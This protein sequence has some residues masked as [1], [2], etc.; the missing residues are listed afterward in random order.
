MRRFKLW[1][2]AVLL[3]LLT[4]TVCPVVRAA[5]ESWEWTEVDTK[6]TAQTQRLV[7]PSQ[8]GD[9]DA[10]APATMARVGHAAV[11][12][13]QP[14]LGAGVIL[15]GGRDADDK[16]LNDAVFLPLPVGK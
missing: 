7:S 1:C 8:S 13:S 3:L 11:A 10:P 2:R 5:S 15:C 12:A 16:L 14:G 4:L 6:K 9:A